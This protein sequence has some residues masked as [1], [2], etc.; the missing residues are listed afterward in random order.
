MGADRELYAV[1]KDG[2]EVPVEIG[3][4]PIKTDEGAFVLAAIVDLTAFK[5]MQAEVVRTQNLAAL[6]EMAATVAHEVKNPLAAISGPLQILADDL[7]PDD[8]RK[9]L[10]KEILGQ[11]RRLDG[12]VRSL[13]T[14]AKPTTPKKHPILLRDFLERMAR[15]AGEHHLG[16][17]IRFTQEGPADL[18]L[19]ADPALL[20]QVFWNLF[21][22]AAEA[23]RG[24]GDLRMTSRATADAVELEVADSG[25]GIAP[26]LLGKL[27]RPFVTTKTSGTG[28]GLAICRKIVE[29]HH[30]SIAI[31][32]DAGQGTKVT[33]RFPKT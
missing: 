22:N 3:L 19:L 28:L 6:G 31:F 33:L 1:R 23:M 27:F 16:R 8:P 29:A 25:G 32:S 10:M 30:G 24:A 5:R 11:V 20:E 14:F 2:T 13:L 12:T 21:L 17:G 9:G 26:E 4:N 7:S 18:L 15:L